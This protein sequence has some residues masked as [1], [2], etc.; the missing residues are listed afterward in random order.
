MCRLDA[1]FWLG[2]LLHVRVLRYAGAAWAMGRDGRRY[3]HL[4]VR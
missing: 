3:M 4:Y 2:K 1:R